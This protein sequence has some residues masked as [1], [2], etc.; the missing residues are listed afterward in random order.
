MAIGSA[1]SLFGRLFAGVMLDRLSVLGV[2]GLFLLRQV[3]GF[4]LLIHGVCWALPAGFLLGAVQGA[5]IDV[6]GYVVARRFW[7]RAYSRNFGTCF[8][9][10]LIG[11]IT[12]PVFMAVI[13]D[14]TGSYV[15][16]LKLL[17]ALPLAA[18][19][20]LWLATSSRRGGMIAAGAAG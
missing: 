17:A 14:R 1:G 19:G 3:A 20:L 15:L 4:L 5:E 16:G 18:F 12:D 13:F 11:A 9:V 10:T 2:A 7:R 8:A 6:M